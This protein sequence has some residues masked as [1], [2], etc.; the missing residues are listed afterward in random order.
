[1]QKSGVLHT[2]TW[3]TVNVETDLEDAC[4]ELQTFFSQ[5]LKHDIIFIP[6]M[7]RL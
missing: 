6:E 1:M 7:Y 2:D 4:N 5:L 3:S